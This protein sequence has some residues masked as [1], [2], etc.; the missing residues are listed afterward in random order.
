MKYAILALVL[1]ILSGQVLAKTEEGLVFKQT[2]RVV[3]YDA[4]NK[5]FDSNRGE[6]GHKLKAEFVND[7]FL[8]TGDVCLPEFCQRYF[9]RYRIIDAPSHGKWVKARHDSFKLVTIQILSQNPLRIVIPG[10][11][12][13]SAKH[14]INANG[15]M[16]YDFGRGSAHQLDYIKLKNRWRSMG[17]TSNVLV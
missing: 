14:D 13:F 16:L 7:L 8:I 2:K 12:N 4:T 1:S 3:I 17:G 9:E 15:R 6:V 10:N 11:G 5:K